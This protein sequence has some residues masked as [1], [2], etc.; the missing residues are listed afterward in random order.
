MKNSSR[1]A[2]YYAPEVGS[3]LADFGASWLG[4][5]PER[6]ESVAHP[7]YADPPGPVSELTDA[8]RKYGFHGTLK[9]PFKLT[10]GYTVS[11]LNDALVELTSQQQAF[12]VERIGLRSIDGFLAITPTRYCAPIATLAENCVRQLDAFRA[13]PLEAE[14]TRRRSAKLSDAQDRNLT[15]WG[16]P[17]VLDEFRF[18]LT[19]TGKLAPEILEPVRER[20]QTEL[21]LILTQPL[22]VREICLFREAKDGNFHIVKRYQLSA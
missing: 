4:W 16:Y 12:E 13:S 3:D 2:V 17:Y 15:R 20:L 22:P 7:A 1:Y 11:D 14:L 9:P 18:H 21:S 10:N 5:D 19:L 6:G 8:P